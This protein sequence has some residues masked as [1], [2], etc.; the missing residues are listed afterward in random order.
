[1][2]HGG[3]VFVAGILP[4]RTWMSESFESDGQNA[5]VHRLDLCLHS[6]PKE[7]WGNGV[8]THVYSKGKIP[9]PGNSPRRRIQPMMLHQVGQWTQ[10][11][12]NKLLGPLWWWYDLTGESGDELLHLLLL[13]CLPY[14]WATKHSHSQQPC[15]Y[16]KMT[17]IRIITSVFLEHLSMWNRL[18]CA[19]QVQI[20]K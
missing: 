4:S 1:M 18:N 20:Q 17:I 11:A 7:F 10:H 5:F 12:T 19:E 9:S 14:R 15:A 16:I 6:H 8:R 3:C 2:V 13:R